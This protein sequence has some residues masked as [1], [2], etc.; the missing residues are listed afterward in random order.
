MTRPQEAMTDFADRESSR[1]TESEPVYR[2]VGSIT[3]RLDE[4]QGS[5]EG[6]VGDGDGVAGRRKRKR[7]ADCERQAA[8]EICG[9]AQPLPSRERVCTTG[10]QQLDTGGISESPAKCAE[11]KDFEELVKVWPA[12]EDLRKA[13]SASKPSRF[14]LEVGAMLGSARVAMAAALHAWTAPGQGA[15]SRA[16]KE[17]Q[18]MYNTLKLAVSRQA[19]V[20]D[21]WWHLKPD[22]AKYL[23]SKI[24]DTVGEGYGGAGS[25]K[26]PPVASAAGF[27]LQSYTTWTPSGRP[28]LFPHRMPFFFSAIADGWPLMFAISTWSKVGYGHMTAN[29]ECFL[30]DRGVTHGGRPRQLF[31]VPSACEGAG[32]LIVCENTQITHI[33][34]KVSMKLHE[35]GGGVAAGPPP[36]QSNLLPDCIRLPIDAATGAPV[37][38]KHLVTTMYDAR[39][40]WEKIAGKVMDATTFAIVN[41]LL[42]MPLKVWP[43]M[44]IHK[45]NHASWELD[46]AAQTAL[47]PTLAKWLAAGNLE[48][49]KK[50]NAMPMFIEPCG[51]VK[52]STPPGFRLITDGRAGN[53]IY[54]PWGVSY[55]TLRDVALVLQRCDFFFSKDIANAYH[56]AAFAGCGQGIIE[57][58]VVYIDA[59]GQ[60]RV[61]KQR[62]IGCSPSTCSGACDKC[63]SGIMLF[64][65]VFRFACCQ[66][67]KATA[68][69]PLNAYIQCL[70][71]LFAERPDPI[72]VQAWVDDLLASVRGVVHDICSGYAGGCETCAKNREAAIKA[73]D[74]FCSICGQ[75]HVWFSDGKGFT[76]DQVGEFTGII[77]N[78]VRGLFSVNPERLMNIVNCLLEIRE[79]PSASRRMIGRGRGKT[80]HYAQAIPYLNQVLPMFTRAIG[81]GVTGDVNWDEHVPV[82]GRL[83]MAINYTIET[84]RRCGEW[85]R[86]MWPLPASSAYRLFQEGAMSD[87]KVATI[88]WDSSPEG[89]GAVIRTSADDDGCLVIGTFEPNNGD[90]FDHQVRRETRGGVLAFKAALKKFKL[91][92]WLI[93]MRND[94]TGALSTLRKGCAKSEFMQNQA[95]EL[96]TLAR[97]HQIE[98][99]FLHAPGK[100]LVAEKVDEASRDGAKEVRGPA[101]TGMLRDA[102]FEL[103]AA[104]GWNITVDLFASVSN[105]LVPR[106]FAR[107]AEPD[108]EGVDALAQTSWSASSCP[109]CGKKHREIF[110]A[111]PPQALI[112]AFVKKAAA[113][114]AAGILIVPYAMT[115]AY[116]PRLKQASVTE[117]G[118][119]W[120]SFKDPGKFLRDT[121]SFKPQALAVFALDFGRDVT[122]PDKRLSAACGQECAARRSETWELPAD[123]I[124]R[125]NIDAKIRELIASRERDSQKSTDHQHGGACGGAHHV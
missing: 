12:L 5:S 43:T 28:Q 108:A 115:A 106:F 3:R 52:K 25:P 49:V 94:A 80:G 103:A 55:H 1:Q 45:T 125:C 17:A 110:Y 105:S 37:F 71:R 47:G 44:C 27:K 85:G 78:S 39:E 121:G 33:I 2:A 26:R 4:P 29:G 79:A 119:P 34:C 13:A 57:E 69:G 73:Y 63:F 15:A 19:G 93:I 18:R 72:S 112:P 23:Q 120:K 99:L 87:K 98:L 50:G 116:W 46:P 107:Y 41:G 117:G 124:D 40:N 70:I 92:G 20:L 14:R 53:G 101:V 31:A 102:V 59:N 51:A 76:P 24:T 88:V 96:V 38:P 82:D 113:D 95:M 122:T 84:I 65:C 22:Q 68:H 111:F 123:R 56:S 118:L 32:A 83:M 7:A 8:E 100:T 114:H 77:I 6:D 91:D 62:F 42:V 74:Y 16:V 109:H 81:D 10:A 75:L 61:R 66:F 36:G 35:D 58:E 48:L 104:Q 97:D 30:V 90:D 21:R 11:E 89:W 60:A 9:E 54:S 64:W 67:G 86:P